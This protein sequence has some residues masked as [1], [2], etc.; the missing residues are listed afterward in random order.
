MQLSFILPIIFNN[1]AYN[2]TVI[3][4]PYKCQEPAS[5]YSNDFHSNSVK[6][7]EL[8]FVLSKLLQS[9]KHGSLN[10]L[11]IYLPNY[12]IFR[13]DRQTPNSRG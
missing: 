8:R 1:A 12:T 9:R 11:Q 10:Q 2:K 3:I 4:L 5:L 13:N 6:M 7:D